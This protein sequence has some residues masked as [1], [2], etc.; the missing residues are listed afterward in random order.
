MDMRKS[1][2]GTE[3]CNMRNLE[4]CILTVRETGYYEEKSINLHLH[5][6]KSCSHVK[7]AENEELLLEDPKY[8]QS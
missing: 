5:H 2:I 7:T 3:L 8:Y 4:K 1:Q 6:S